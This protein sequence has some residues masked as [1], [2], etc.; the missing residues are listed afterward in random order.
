MKVTTAL[1]FIILLF[2]AG[3]AGTIP[4]DYEPHNFVRYEGGAS[5]GKFT[6]KPAQTGDV[7]PNQIQNTALGSIYMAVKVADLVQRATA[8]ELEKTGFSI[9]SNNPL[10]VSGTVLEFK[11]ADFGYSV[12][13]TYVI[14]Y[15]ISRKETGAELL[16]EVYAADP[17]TTGKFGRPADY[18]P[19]INELILS[20][21]GNIRDPQVRKLL[22]QQ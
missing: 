8:L 5:I 15:V 1:G 13:W 4:V 14:R 16:N 2:L 10:R 21:Y 11:A 22:S 12:D 9:G 20:A 6:Y 18:A 17:V 3:C 19:S 7:A